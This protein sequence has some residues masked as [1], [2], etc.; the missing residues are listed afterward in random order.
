MWGEVFENTGMYILEKELLDQIDTIA[1]AVKVKTNNVVN[2]EE[3]IAIP[4]FGNIIPRFTLDKA[5][6]SLDELDSYEKMIYEVVGNDF[7]IDFMGDVYKRVGVD[8]SK[9]D[10]KLNKFSQRYKDEAAYEQ[11]SYASDIRK[12]AEYLLAKAGL[13][14][15]QFVWEIQVDEDELIV[16]I[17]GEEHKKIAEVEGKPNIC[18]AE[19]PSTQCLGLYKATLYAKRNQISLARLLVEG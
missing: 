3:Y 9:L 14:T 12:D 6:V 13:D 15:D 11:A 7:L 18:V 10:D 1:K 8:F 2:Y 16:L 19:V 4:Y 17:M 5:A